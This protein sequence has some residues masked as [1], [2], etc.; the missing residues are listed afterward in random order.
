MQIQNESERESESTK[1]SGSSGKSSSI[2]IL[3]LSSNSF[4]LLFLGR[5]LTFRYSLCEAQTL[6]RSGLKPWPSDIDGFRDWE[7]KPKRFALATK[8]KRA[9]G[10]RTKATAFGVWLRG[11]AAA[12]GM[13]RAIVV[14]NVDVRRR[15]ERRGSMDVSHICTVGYRGGYRGVTGFCFGFVS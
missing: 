15:G 9:E 1:T 12:R 8:P 6:P 10:R 4:S 7:T 14:G 2:Q 13:T 3:T 5:L 11:T